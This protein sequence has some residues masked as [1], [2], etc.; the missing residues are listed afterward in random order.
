MK[1]ITGIIEQSAF[2]EKELYQST[3]VT[4]GQQ[5]GVPCNLADFSLFSAILAKFLDI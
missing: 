3:T 1:S 2:R 4:T 5:C